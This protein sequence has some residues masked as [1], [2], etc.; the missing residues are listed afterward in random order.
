LA[1]PNFFLRFHYIIS[2]STTFLLLV[3]FY[4][5]AL[6][7]DRWDGVGQVFVDCGG[8]NTR[9]LGGR[10]WEEKRSEMWAFVSFLSEKQK[11]FESFYVGNIG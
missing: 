10:V 8:I 5:C 11:L 9:W 7:N 6:Y 1:F 2:L 4:L 3:L